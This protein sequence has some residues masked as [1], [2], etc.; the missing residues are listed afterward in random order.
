MSCRRSRNLAFSLRFSCLAS[1]TR[2]AGHTCRL[3]ARLRANC[4]RLEKPSHIQ[5]AHA[6][7]HHMPHHHPRAPHHTL[8]SLDSYLTL[9]PSFHAG[10]YATDYVRPTLTCAAT[11]HVCGAECGSASDLFTRS[12][13]CTRFIFACGA[14]AGA[15]LRPTFSRPEQHAWC[16]LADTLY[17]SE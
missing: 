12:H 11:H 10:H 15:A 1:H 5:H 4:G 6:T 14:T 13:R 3:E 17:D 16:G 2:V 8:W 9:A 7:H